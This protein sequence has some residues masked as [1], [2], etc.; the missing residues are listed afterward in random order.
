MPDKPAATMN[1]YYKDNT[2]IA[3][4]FETVDDFLYQ[5]EKQVNSLKILSKNKFTL[6][7]TNIIIKIYT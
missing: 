4:E 2:S 7:P 6:L 3:M 1:I 5:L